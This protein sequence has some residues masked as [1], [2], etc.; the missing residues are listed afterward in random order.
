MGVTM[1]IGPWANFN[2]CLSHMEGKEG[3]SDESAHKVCGKLKADL[4]KS[5]ANPFPGKSLKWLYA[6][7]SHQQKQDWMEAREKDRK[8]QMGKGV[9]QK[10]EIVW[11]KPKDKLK[12]LNPS[13]DPVPIPQYERSDKCA[14]N[15][16]LTHEEDIKKEPA[17]TRDN[18]D[19][20]GRPTLDFDP[21][22][23]SRRSKKVFDPKGMPM[24]LRMEKGNWK[25]FIADEDKKKIPEKILQDK[26]TPIKPPPIKKDDFDEAEKV[27]DK[28][29]KPSGIPRGVEG[30]QN[31]HGLAGSNK[32]IGKACPCAGQKVE[33]EHAD[34]LKKLGVPEEKIPEAAKMI[35]ADHVGE[36]DDYYKRLKM[37]EKPDFWSHFKKAD[38]PTNTPQIKPIEQEIT[39]LR[40]KSKLSPGMKD[41]KEVKEVK[42][43][44]VEKEWNLNL[45][46]LLKS[47]REFSGTFH[48]PVIDKEN[49]IIPASAMDK[50]MDDFM[51][52]PTLQEVHTERT[53][54]IVTKAW[55]NGDDE[56]YLE[57]RIK[58]GD[59]CDDVWQKI[60]KG[61]YDGLSIGGRR[62]SYS[63]EC[64]IPSLIRDTPCVTH[65]LKLYN[66]SVCSS[67][68][69]PEA[70]IDEFNKVAKGEE[71]YDLDETLKKAMTTGSSLSH[72]IYDGKRKK[73]E[74]NEVTTVDK[75]DEN[76]ITK[77]DI[78][79]LTKAILELQ[80]SF[81][82]HFASL[83]TPQPQGIS[84]KGHSVEDT[85][86]KGKGKEEE[87]ELEDEEY[88][89]K[90]KKIKKSDDVPENNFE[91]IVKAQDAKI[92][93]LQSQLE[94]LKDTTVI[95]K[96]GEAVIIPEQLLKSD[97]VL[98]NMGMLSGMGR[99]VK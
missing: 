51:V 92:A 81:A 97:P 93:E 37:M 8:E 56:Y 87:E 44:D 88:S 82:S 71:I 61:E 45:D 15:V 27:K 2:A 36:T 34:T 17:Q 4:E 54:G 23:K 74:E 84:G 35:A 89:G 41:L 62:I 95:R 9:D 38:D 64:A 11:A 30:K 79:D 29:N 26:D 91:L 66:V 40:L 99:Q 85:M 70:S 39:Q 3:Y 53:V 24:S 50:A 76:L 19:V 75:S 47:E 94:K 33:M 77:S 63:K 72:G 73:M 32:T 13:T 78:E 14:D 67:P 25:M 58:P 28:L 10:R 65:R 42:K 31:W 69:N 21:K 59:D 60:K 55:K 20:G 48:K 96:G 5:E 86:Q 90:T 68:V 1:P 98:T 80:K 43:D 6:D 7:Y 49:D 12:N 57:G 83:T 18:P 22:E 46:E 52:L 16:C